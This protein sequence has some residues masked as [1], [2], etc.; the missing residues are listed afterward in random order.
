[1]SGGGRRA[2]LVEGAVGSHLWRLGVPMAFGF[3]F[4]LLFQIVDT[5]W[6]GQLGTEPLA[7]IGYT[8]PIGF[9]IM[10]IAL[11]LAV[12]TASVLSHAI[13]A[14]QEERATRLATDAVAL[15]V[16]IVVPTSV[17]GMLTIDQ[18]FGA[19]GATGQVLE[20]VRDYME[21][22][23][24]GVGMLFMPIVGNA[25]IRAT[26][27]TRTPAV[28][29]GLSGGLNMVLDPLMIFGLAGFPRMEVQGAAL[30]TVLSWGLTSIAALALLRWR[31]RLIDLRPPRLAAVLESWKAI[32]FVAGP[33]AA[34]SMV[35]P[36]S[37]AVLTAMLSRFGDEAVAAYGVGVR[38]EP[39]A[40]IG[41]M[42][43]AS[44]LPVFVGQN[45]GAGQFD[46]VREGLRLSQRFGLT[47]GLGIW[48]LL[49]AFR[50]PLAS[51]FNDDPRVVELIARFLVIL[52]ASYGMLAVNLLITSALNA[53]N[54]P[55]QSA[56]WAAM[57][58][59]V[60]TVPL[61]WIG[62]RWTGV[63][64]VFWGAA[65][66]N[67]LAGA[68]TWLWFRRYLDRQVEAARRR[69]EATAAAPAAGVSG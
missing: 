41:T 15:S 27:D 9:L 35:V 48:L 21:I 28:I 51:S 33:A 29:M 49:F 39:I 44:A 31:E 61:A 60:L 59:F 11:G 40:M 19:M 18:V 17:I 43:L 50:W 52:P 23:Y 20:Y 66:A 5:F 30:A 16:V 14:G 3:L 64:G 65:L 69:R 57:R 6:V 54:R 10:S 67:V 1:M 55:L 47:W 62:S 53:L 13:G 25:A 12:G 46:R 37:A 58:M 2:R 34:T 7:A 36:I 38:I 32:L 63:E 56:A 26:G 8:F 45:W 24:P 22:W 4:V 42:A 68:L